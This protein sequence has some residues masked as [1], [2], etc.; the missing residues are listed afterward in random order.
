MR[1]ERHVIITLT[2]ITF[3][4][5]LQFRNLKCQYALIRNCHLEVRSAHSTRATY[6]IVR[7]CG[8]KSML[9]AGTVIAMHLK[10]VEWQELPSR[11]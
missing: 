8:L 7:C 11:V 1:L 9:V 2:S 6:L 3:A 4:S 5:Q 10:S